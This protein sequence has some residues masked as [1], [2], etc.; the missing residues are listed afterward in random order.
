MSISGEIQRLSTAKSQISTKMQSFG[1]SQS[2]DKLDDLADDLSQ[3][4]N[5]GSITATLMS[6]YDAYNIPD[7]YHN[8]SGQVKGSSFNSTTISQIVLAQDDQPSS[9]LTHNQVWIDTDSAQEYV[10]PTIDEFNA[11]VARVEALERIA[12]NL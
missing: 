3:M 4:P 6:D 2:T 5:R 9:S 12:A 1:L 10:V 8:G 7:G 11:L